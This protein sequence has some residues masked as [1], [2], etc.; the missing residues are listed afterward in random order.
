MLGEHHSFVTFS[1][2]KRTASDVER[3]IGVIEEVDTDQC[4]ALPLPN[5]FL[6][7]EC[8]FPGVFGSL[9]GIRNFGF[10]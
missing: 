5:R 8:G 3:S 4:I 2:G 10:G 1:R 9:G 7:S 6:F